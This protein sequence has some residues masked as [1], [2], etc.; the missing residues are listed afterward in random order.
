MRSVKLMDSVFIAF[1]AMTEHLSEATWGKKFLL[2]FMGVHHIII[3]VIACSVKWCSPK[4]QRLVV[5]FVL[6]LVDQEAEMGT[7]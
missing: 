7:G 1:V 2:W 4:Q 6:V 3:A 5:G